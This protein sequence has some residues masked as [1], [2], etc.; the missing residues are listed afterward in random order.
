M[1]YDTR[2]HYSQMN[3]NLEQRNR[4]FR[5]EPIFSLQSGKD[6]SIENIR[7]WTFIPDFTSSRTEITKKTIVRNLKP[8]APTR[9]KQNVSVYRHLEYTTRFNQ[10]N[11]EAGLTRPFICL[12]SLSIHDEQISLNTNLIKENFKL[13]YCEKTRFYYLILNAEVESSVEITLSYQ[14]A[15]RPVSWYECPE[16]VKKIIRHF[17]VPYQGLPPEDFSTK[18]L[19]EKLSYIAAH[20]EYFDCNTRTNV[21][22]KTI[23]THKEVEDSRHAG[24]GLHSWPEIKIKGEWFQI[25]LGGASA[26]LNYAK[27]PDSESSLSSPPAE[28]LLDPRPFLKAVLEENTVNTNVLLICRSEKAHV[29][30]VRAYLRSLAPQNTLA[31]DRFEDSLSSSPFIRLEIQKHQW[32]PVV[33]RGSDGWLARCTHS[34]PKKLINLQPIVAFNYQ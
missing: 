12:D 26:V 14:L 16:S 11:P 23:R 10:P 28:V 1:I 34:Y 25:D 3:Y 22:L 5:L 18:S 9:P 29:R 4:N 8:Y 6:L 27:I 15:V 2:V 21:F 31:L 24:S 33:P 32:S 30:A 20:P 17:K 19:E 7:L 13:Q